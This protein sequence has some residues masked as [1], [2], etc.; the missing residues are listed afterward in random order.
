M[1][2][3]I[4]QTVVRALSGYGFS[5]P[6]DVIVT[7]IE[8]NPEGEFF[9]PSISSCHADADELAGVCLAALK[10]AALDPAAR[11]VIRYKSVTH[12]ANSCCQKETDA[13]SVTELSRIITGMIRHEDHMFS[14]MDEISGINDPDSLYSALS[15]LIS[16]HSVL[17]LNRNVTNLLSG[18]EDCV[19]SGVK[20]DYTV[21]YAA[22]S[23]SGRE[24]RSLQPMDNIIPDAQEWA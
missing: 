15:Q 16:S 4:A 21:I 17:C 9:Q 18:R 24:L 13:H 19:S 7:G 8:E 14:W 5:V 2:D 11:R 20:E 6:R 23:N 10:D 1:N 3:H 12:I 22:R